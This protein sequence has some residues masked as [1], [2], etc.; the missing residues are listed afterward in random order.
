MLCNAVL[1]FSVSASCVLCRCVLVF[2][3]FVCFGVRCCGRIGWGCDTIGCMRIWVSAIRINDQTSNNRHAHNNTQHTTS[4]EYDQR[5]RRMAVR[6]DVW[7]GF[8]VHRRRHGNH[9]KK[10]PHRLELGTVVC[11]LN[12]PCTRL[13]RPISV[14]LRVPHLVCGFVCGVCV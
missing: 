5:H 4:S 11:S 10:T 13:N 6:Y 3:L 7:I 2:C 1:F 14:L 12:P 9:Q 8:V